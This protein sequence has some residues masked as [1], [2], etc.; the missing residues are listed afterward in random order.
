MS[1][2]TIQGA[3]SGP[4]PVEAAPPGA[5]LLDRLY[6]DHVARLQD[7]YSAALERHGFDALVIHAG[8][9]ARVSAFDD[10]YWPLRPTPAF[11]HWLPLV[12]ADAALVIEPGRQPRLLH[13]RVSDFWESEPTLESTRFLDAFDELLVDGPIEPNRMLGGKR[14]AFVGELDVRATRWGIPPEEVNPVSLLAA[15]DQVRA[16][17]SEYERRCIAEANRRAARGH[18]QVAEAFLAGDHSELELYLLYL[19]ASEQSDV[20]PPYQSIVA[21]DRHAAVLHHVHYDR[22]RMGGKNGSS[23]GSLLVDAG[24]QY[25]GYASDITRTYAKGS[26]HGAELFA[27]LVREMEAL[28]AEICRRVRPGLPFEDLHDQAHV[29]LAPILRKLG[30]SSAPDDELVASG[31]TR[32]LFPHGLGHC[33]GIQVHD[34]GCRLT[35]PRADNPFLRNTSVIAPGQVFTIEPGCYFIP[36]L[37]DDLRA[38]P[39][40]ASFDWALVAEI[41]R[42]GGVRVEDNVAVVDGGTVNLTRDNWPGAP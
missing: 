25:R 12:K 7:A 32:C 5:E 40:G 9:P 4:V 37:L 34:V 18:R 24:A 20:D 15:L 1:D 36:G 42:F 8:V 16:H 14:T 10:R 39:V 21:M 2:E 26:E 41:S 31:A 28:Q 29:L 3:D 38:R 17:K 27:T 6:L 13:S 11:A 33:L 30:L 22:E 19:Q 35:P 23:S